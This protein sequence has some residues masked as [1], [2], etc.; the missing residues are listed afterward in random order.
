MAGGKNENGSI[1]APS[2]SVDPHIDDAA[3]ERGGSPFPERLLG[4]AASGF[5]WGALFVMR[6]RLLVAVPRA[7]VESETK[8]VVWTGD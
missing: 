4:L 3:A 2:P 7:K 6:G 1:A 8:Q 5:F